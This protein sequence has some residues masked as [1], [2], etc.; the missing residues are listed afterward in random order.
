MPQ[1]RIGAPGVSHRRSRLAAAVIMALFTYVIFPA[2]D[3]AEHDPDRIRL[4]ETVISG[5]QELPKVLYILP[6]Q[7]P[8]GRPELSLDAGLEDENVLRRVYPPAHR[9][10]LRYWNGLKALESGRGRRPAD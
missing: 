8:E 10:E 7:S 9:R 5:N 3:A 1:P 6:W 2:A 4:D